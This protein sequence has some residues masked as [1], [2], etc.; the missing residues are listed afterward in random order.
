[1]RQIET[2]ARDQALRWFHRRNTHWNWEAEV[3][4]EDLLK[5]WPA[6]PASAEDSSDVRV[7]LETAAA[8]HSLPLPTSAELQRLRVGLV[9]L[10]DKV[11]DAIRSREA[12]GVPADV[13]GDKID[14]AKKDVEGQ[15]LARLA[16]GELACFI[17]TN[18]GVKRLPYEGYWINA[19]GSATTAAQRALILGTATA[20]SDTRLAGTVMVKIDDFDVFAEE[21]LKERGLAEDRASPPVIQISRAPPP[22]SPLRGSNASALLRYAEDERRSP[23]WQ[24]WHLVPEVKLYEAVALSLGIDPKKLCHNLHSWMG[25][26]RFKEDQ[27][28]ADRL[29]IAERNLE[30]LRPLNSMGMRYYDDDPVIALKAFAA[31]GVSIGW[32]LPSEL[33]DIAAGASGAPPPAEAP[34]GDGKSSEQPVAKPEPSSRAPGSDRTGIE[35]VSP[36]RGGRK[37]GSGSINDAE[38][39]RAMLCLLAGRQANSVH[40]A[41]RKIAQSM[42]E[43][44]QSRDADVSRLRSKFA[45]DHGTEPPAG[46]TW[47][48]VAA[49]L[50]AN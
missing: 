11:A 39:I 20:P 35:R 29:F 6:P 42:K 43:P 12:A 28:F 13:V 7:D 45:N 10:K 41:A 25:G 19:D 34:E 17:E 24:V 38:R 4:R 36:G 23:N 46:R 3:S 47:A 9:V 5:L 49:E 8:W 1:M 21:Y 37:K 50:N 14:Q 18:F 30:I 40:Q 26:S 16:R 15:L 33:A 27:E 31:W 22:I 44:I 2:A 48:D 32:D